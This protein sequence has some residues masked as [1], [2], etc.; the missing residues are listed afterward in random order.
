MRSK[1]NIEEF[2]YMVQCFEEITIDDEKSAK[3]LV[4]KELPG[5]EN[6]DYD[7]IVIKNIS[8]NFFLLI[9]KKVWKLQ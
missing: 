9:I 3:E 7:D 8:G 5:W 2:S 6:V 4:L 1:F